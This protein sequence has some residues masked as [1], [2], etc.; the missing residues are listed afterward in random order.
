MS[1]TA[2]RPAH[3]VFAASG[4]RVLR[5]GGTALTER[6]LDQ[7]A[8]QAGA[9]VVEFAPG[10]G[11]TAE[12]L[13]DRDPATYRGID[14]D[15]D[16]VARLRER[17]GGPNRE[18]LTGHAAE[19]GLERSSADVCVGE[20]MLTMQ[21]DDGARAIVDEAARLLRATGRYGIHELAVHDDVPA[22]RQDQIAL[23]LESV[24]GV[25]ARPRT[26][27]TWVDI[28]D[29]EGFTVEWTDR[30]PMALLDPRRLVADEGVLGA[31]RFGA[32]V[33]RDRDA[34][35]RVRSIRTTFREHADAL[36]A[37]AVVARRD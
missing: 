22:D 10:T 26:E 17:L 24:L 1:E 11:A 18:F 15:A 7:I 25:P 19:T 28:L 32:R 31:I 13:L 34:R 14:L 8:L 2:D 27:S 4:K 35:Q 33:L 23:D 9:D 6:L 30:A 21:A 29:Q 36:T 3:Q 37:L 20:A 16:T 12:R 5:P